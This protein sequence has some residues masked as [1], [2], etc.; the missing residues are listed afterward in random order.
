MEKITF[1]LSVHSI[2]YEGT[3]TRLIELRPSPGSYLPPVEAGSHIDV[4]ISPTIIRQYSLCNT[5]GETHRYVIGV[6]LDPSSRGGSR[7]LHEVL[8]EGDTLKVGAPRNHFEL[9]QSENHTVLIGGGIGITP[10]LSMALQLEA[11]QRTW[12]LHYAAKSADVAPLFHSICTLA[13]QARYGQV[14]MY[15]SQ[16]SIQRMKVSDVMANAPDG[17]HF[18]CCGPLK[19]MDDFDSCSVHYPPN[20]CHSERFCGDV[21]VAKGGFTIV[22]ARTG[23]EIYIS[24]ES[25][26]LNALKAE[27][28]NVTY[29]CAEG[30]CGSCEVKVLEGKPDHRDE[31]LSDAE[32]ARNDTMMV[33]CSGAIT[34]RLVLDL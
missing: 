11:Q 1:T 31:V 13:H 12:S 8:K 17:S 28:I 21:D 18:Y 15:F 4:H 6:A 32:K 34:N 25:T 19:L 10:L 2:S 14:N 22:L 33:C 26:I 29:A 7:A 30:V 3:H 16:Q 20:H 23:K 9:I 27:R 5:P 24:E